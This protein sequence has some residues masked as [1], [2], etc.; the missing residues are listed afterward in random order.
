MK[1]TD[2]RKISNGDTGAK[3]ASIIYENDTNL[4]NGSQICLKQIE[5]NRKII[6]EASGGPI[7]FVIEEAPGQSI[8]NGMSQKAIT[9][10]LFD[11]SSVTSGVCCIQD[12][13]SVLNASGETCDFANV[14]EFAKYDENGIELETAFD[15]IL[16]YKKANEAILNNMLNRV[17]NVE[18][19]LARR[20]KDAIDNMPKDAEWVNDDFQDD[21]NDGQ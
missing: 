5:A 20:Y 12:E 1:E 3:V 11:E 8:S 10:A 2:L 16:E 17:S 4:F 15:K 19:E 9:K 21:W 7:Q 6:D 14:A 18:R 13:I